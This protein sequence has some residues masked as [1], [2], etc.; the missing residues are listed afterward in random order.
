MSENKNLEL[1]EIIKKYPQKRKML[2]MPSFSS[3]RQLLH[4]LNQEGIKI[5]NCDLETPLGLLKKS[6]ELQ[7]FNDNL[8]LIENQQASYLIYR[9]LIELKAEAKLKYFDQL[10]LSSGSI[11]LLAGT[12]LEYRMAGY[13]TEDI[14]ANKFIKAEKTEDLKLINKSYQE[15]LKQE[16]Y[17]DQAAAYH[18]A[19]TMEKFNL[20]E[21]VIIQ[22]EDIELSS[23]ERKFLNKIKSQSSAAYNFKLNRNNE[24]NF[25][26]E[27]LA[28]YGSTNEVNNIL[29]KITEADFKADQTTVYYL[30]QEPYSQQFY[31]LA[32]NYN[33][34]VSFAG[35]I[36]INNTKA[37]AVYY[38]YLAE[39][40]ENPN[41]ENQLRAAD[42]AHT[43]LNIIA[44]LK[45]KK[46]IDQ[47]AKNIILR[48]LKLFIKYFD[49]LEAK[50]VVIRRLQDLI[51]DERVNIS[52]PEPGKIY[53]APSTAALY[54]NRK[55]EIF[56][57]LEENNISESQS[58]NPVILDFE[59]NYYPNLSLSTEKNKKALLDLETVIYKN[60][61]NKLLSYSNYS[62]QDSREQLPS[63]LLLDAYRKRETD[64]T[65]TFKDFKADAVKT[66]A[67]APDSAANS[68]NLNEYFLSNF[69]AADKITNKKELLLNFYPNFEKGLEFLDAELEPEF[70]K[71]SGR[72]SSIFKSEAQLQAEEP[73]YS[74]SRLETIAKCPYKY[75]LNYVLGISA[76]EEA[77]LDPFSWLSPLEQGTLLHSV[78][79]HFIKEMIESSKQL[80]SEEKRRLINKI[81]NEEAEKMRLEVIPPSELI[82]QLK[83][84]ELRERTDLFLSL[85]EMELKDSEP[86]FVERF[87]DNYILKLNSGREI[88]LRGKIDRIDRL[89]DGSYRII[90]YK[91]GGD[92]SYSEQEYFKEGT[93]LQPALYSAAFAE[94]LEAEVREF[95][96]LFVN[97]GAVKKKYIR[98]N[99]RKEKLKEILDILL[100]TAEAGT[101]IA[102]AYD[103]DNKECKYCDYNQLICERE[104][105]DKLSELFKTSAE[106]AVKKL[107][108]LKDYE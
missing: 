22:P 46:D 20:K 107:R 88:K 102:A 90:D 35:G 49:L 103:K 11:N 89:N 59:R 58:E 24:E 57:G 86:V 101:F 9:V 61:A 48:K 38:N 17:L 80:D 5:F 13:N 50:E 52:G 10:Q 73:V 56:I 7:L 1:K 14:E 93:Q 43:L 6:L 12:I 84:K 55:N 26:A 53:L 75:F 100:N 78:F 98:K 34:A 33:L 4:N 42:V 3:G 96:Y 39:L 97:Q 36:S 51:K 45:V 82:Y 77:E 2:L 85:I 66:T 71:Y 74:S 62:I 63:F 92:Y 15:K 83:L 47:E 28:A 16:N 19:L 8:T 104:K 72:L 44:Q 69:K 99:N 68:L 32:Q 54:S 27:F 76:P 95:L 81:L 30:S 87:F 18:L 29:R 65:L 60:S 25:E 91:T 94:E 108:G 41:Y 31:N 64:Q 70:N 40:R 37:A 105:D 23:L 21:A 67:F 79:E 106:A